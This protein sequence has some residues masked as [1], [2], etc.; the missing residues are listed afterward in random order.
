MM[1]VEHDIEAEFVAELPLVV[2]TM[3]QIGGDVRIAFAIREGDAKRR[4]GSF[5][6]GK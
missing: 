5:Q 4:C 3:E 1:L 6:A 2:V